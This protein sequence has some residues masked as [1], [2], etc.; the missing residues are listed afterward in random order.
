[1]ATSNELNILTLLNQKR[2]NNKLLNTVAEYV[3][4]YDEQITKSEQNTAYGSILAKFREDI[5]KIT[6]TKNTTSTTSTSNTTNTQNT[7]AE[8]TTTTVRRNVHYVATTQSQSQINS[9]ATTLYKD[10]YARNMFGLPTT[11]KNIK[12]HVN[13]ITADNVIEVL[14]A[15]YKKTGNDKE[16]LISAIFHEV[17]LS[18][19]D[20]AKMV[21]HIEDCLLERYESMGIYVDDFR[22]SIKK[23]INYQKNKIGLMSGSLLDKINENLKRRFDGACSAQK[24]IEADGSINAANQQGTTGD[25]W[26]LASI[27]AIASSPKGK[28]ILDDSVTVNSNNT[29]TVHLKGVNKT[30]TFT[31]EELLGATELST[32]DLDIRALEKAVEKYM[33]ENKHD[34]INGNRSSVAFQILLGKG[35]VT[36]DY[37][38][39]IW[40]RFIGID[41]SYKKKIN[42]PNTIC[43]AAVHESFGTGNGGNVVYTTQDGVKIYSHHVY[44]VVRCD[45]KYVYLINPWNNQEEIRMTFNEFKNTFNYFCE[46]TL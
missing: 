25:C 27:N 26:L 39:E 40:D 6:T 14:E 9:I 11:G 33:M 5:S 15:Y 23:E 8:Q 22:K 31:R 35:N 18:A 46:V 20:R 36:L 21:Q 12:K 1:M 28:Q 17:G 2:A 43:T 37:L 30:Y 38:D 44:S 45:D 42:D 41:S 34:D 7:T 19:K 32:G 10:I 13:Q 24:I 3:N 29:I 4:K 16:S